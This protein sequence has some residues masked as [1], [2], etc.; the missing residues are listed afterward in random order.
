[1]LEGCVQLGGVD[2]E[3][4]ELTEDVGEPE[5]D[6]ADLALGND[7]LDVVRGDW[8]GGHDL[9]LLIAVHRA[10]GTSGRYM[11]TLNDRLGIGR[12]APPPCGAS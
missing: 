6:E 9:E 8:L 7:R 4:L 1:M 5:V 12:F 10:G 3:R 11:G 2:R